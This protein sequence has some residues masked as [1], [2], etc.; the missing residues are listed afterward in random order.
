MAEEGKKKEPL[1]WFKKMK[2]KKKREWVCVRLDSLLKDVL[3]V[4]PPVVLGQFDGED[5]T[6][7]EKDGAASQAKPEGVLENR[8]RTK[9][10][11]SRAARSQR[12]EMMRIPHTCVSVYRVMTQTRSASLCQVTP[13]EA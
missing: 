6:R 11:T 8:R 5:D 4:H 2:K 13:Q 1:I 12:G 7:N 3:C 10:F 9:T